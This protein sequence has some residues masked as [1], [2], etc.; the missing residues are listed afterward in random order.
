MSQLVPDFQHDAFDFQSYG[1]AFHWTEHPKVLGV[2]HTQLCAEK[3]TEALGKSICVMVSSLHS[4]P[5]AMQVVRMVCSMW[6]KHAFL[7]FRMVKEWLCMWVAL[8]TKFGVF[9]RLS[10]SLCTT[11]DRV[12]ALIWWSKSHHLF[13][14]NAPWKHTMP[15]LCLKPCRGGGHDFEGGTA[16]ISQDLSLSFDVTDSMCCTNHVVVPWSH[17]LLP[18]ENVIPFCDLMAGLNLSD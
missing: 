7:S 6:K 2:L 10:S 12:L 1:Q 13:E 18:T 17:F 4:L 8:K 9:L 11:L 16:L 3:G 5:V 14:Q 15:E